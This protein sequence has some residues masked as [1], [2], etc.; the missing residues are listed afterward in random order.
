[1]RDIGSYTHEYP[2]SNDEKIWN[3]KRQ[4]CGTNTLNIKLYEA[5]VQELTGADRVIIECNYI[6]GG[7][8]SFMVRVRFR[9]NVRALPPCAMRHLAVQTQ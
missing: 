2:L 5:S 4:H 1:M 6:R 3:V 7:V 9:V 8:H